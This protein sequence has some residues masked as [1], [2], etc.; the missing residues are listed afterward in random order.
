VLYIEDNPSNLRLVTKILGK[1]THIHLI[2]AHTPEL[3]IELALIHKPKL[4]LLDINMPGL[5]GYQVLKI[6]KAKKTLNSIPVV[7]IT[8]NAMPRDIEKGMAAG[9]TEY[10][11]K[12]LDVIRFY[13]ILDKLLGVNIRRD[14]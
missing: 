13:A 12:P 11:T 2:T 5:N 1:S 3:G 9:F 10:L 7:A 14:S 8:A 6:I 4:I